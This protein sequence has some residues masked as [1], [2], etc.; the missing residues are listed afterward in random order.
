MHQYLDS[1][2][3]GTSATCVS[4]TIG[5]ERLASATTWLQQNNLKGFL[6]E[7]GAG[8]NTQCI[9][10]VQGALCSMQQ[11]GAW[12]GMDAPPTSFFLVLI[13][14]TQVLYGGL[15]DHGGQ[16]CVN[17][18]IYTFYPILTKHITVFPIYRATQWGCDC[19]SASP[20]SETVPVICKQYIVW[21]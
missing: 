21:R 10:A 14:N 18:A 11:S 1:D 15:Q 16:T 20:G 13:T 9:Q 8:N 5:S 17:P 4:S 12:I 2:G 19:T 3:S 6:G 7:I